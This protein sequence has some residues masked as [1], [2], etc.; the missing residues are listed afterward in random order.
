MCDWEGLERGRMASEEWQSTRAMEAQ[1]IVDIQRQ[2]E[3]R[4]RMRIRE[5]IR[6]SFRAPPAPRR[7]APQEL[8]R[9][10]D[11]RTQQD[12]REQATSSSSQTPRKGSRRKGSRRKGARR[13]G[14]QTEAT[15]Q[16]RQRK[17]QDLAQ[18]WNKENGWTKGF[19]EHRPRRLHVSREGTH[20]PRAPV[21][22][23]PVISGVCSKHIPVQQTIFGKRL[24]STSKRIVSKARQRQSRRK[25]R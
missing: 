10:S 22:N 14:A 20:T 17:F 12:Y 9:P 2:F 7:D 8:Q 1:R 13:K 25:A 18:A 23:V 19:V 3:D 21:Q 6:S 16:E 24:Q 15:Q 4:N 5:Q 11:G